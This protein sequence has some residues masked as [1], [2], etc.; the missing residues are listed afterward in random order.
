MTR[1]NRRLLLLALAFHLTLVVSFQALAAPPSPP[2]YTRL[3][4]STAA[5]QHLFRDSWTTRSSGPEQ[6]KRVFSFFHRKSQ[7]KEEAINT[8]QRRKEQWAQ[9]YT[10]VDALRQRFGSNRNF[11]WG[12]LDAGTT[13]RLYKTLLPKA[14]LELYNLGVQPQDLAPLAYRARVAAKLYARER[15]SL[16]ARVAANLYDGFRQ[17]RRYGS[18][19]TSGMSY[20][21]VWEKYSNVILDEL[22]DDNE[23]DD[24]E[25]E[26]VTARICLKILERSCSTNEMVDNLVLKGQRSAEDRKDLQYVTETLEQDV[27]NL[28]QPV[29]MPAQQLSAQR[30]KTLRRIVRLK[31]RL[32]KGLAVKETSDDEFEYANEFTLE[33]EQEQ[34]DWRG[35]S[36]ARSMMLKTPSSWRQKA[37]PFGWMNRRP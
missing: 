5:P 2:Q 35:S 37:R 8:Y 16:P 33:E 29:P 9:Q 36:S 17:W 32:E 28:L 6:Q 7:Q 10:T 13:R 14:L 27:R 18:F 1:T 34:H 25:P 23:E 22:Q 19:D 4:A 11:V 24:L 3:A 26:D 21:Q 31:R 15:C 30:I 20:Q 12:D